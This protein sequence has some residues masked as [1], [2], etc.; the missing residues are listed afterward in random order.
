MK[1]KSVKVIF[2][3]QKH[4]YTTSVNGYCSEST[5]KDYFIGKMFDVGVFPEGKMRECIN[6][7]IC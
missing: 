3:D 7:E 4:N 5:L 6:I 1:L 2:E